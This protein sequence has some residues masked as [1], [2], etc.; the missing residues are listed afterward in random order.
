M[1]R[2]RVPQL[3]KAEFTFSVETNA[4]ML[5]PFDQV[6]REWVG[7]FREIERKLEKAKK[8][9]NE[10]ETEARS[11]FQS[12]YHLEFAKNLTAL[13]EVENE[14]NHLQRM[15]QAIDSQMTVNGLNRRAAFQLVN[16]RL[17]ANHDPF[18]SEE[19]LERFRCEQ[20]RMFQEAFSKKLNRGGTLQV[21]VE[22]LEEVRKQTV[23]EA[24]YR[25][26]QPKTA[27]E[28]DFLNAWIED[29][30]LDRYENQNH[31][32]REQEEYQAQTHDF[33]LED[34]DY[35]EETS[36]EF[37]EVENQQPQNNPDVTKDYKTLYRGVVR[38]LHPDRGHEMNAVEKE[39][40]AQ[41]QSAYRRKDEVA[42]REILLRIE[43][44]GRIDIHRLETIGEIRDL[45]LRLHLEFS[46][47]NYLKSRVKKEAV[48][49][50][51]ASR[52][53]PTNRKKLER[54]IADELRHS[55][56]CG[57]QELRELKAEKKRMERQLAR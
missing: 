26:G 5:I 17:A 24:L 13:R 28:E 54:E 36:N 30:I 51:W 29:V 11:L 12:W 23:Q 15:F 25:F 45:T 22:R 48:Y 14:I 20:Q 10:F 49:R 9:W 8:E 56:Y 3:K 55:F 18:P 32:K 16:D 39:L 43:G 35:F 57:E 33:D 41:A 1:K 34:E 42:L 7:Y 6:K 53:R 27:R 52:K 4:L 50:F 40:W 37:D 21:D 38:L 31:E 46:E 2:I 44:D 19:E 47:V